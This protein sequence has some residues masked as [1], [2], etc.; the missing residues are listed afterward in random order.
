MRILLVEDEPDMA[1]FIARGLKE[2]C[3]AL[4]VVHDGAKA[5]YYAELTPYDL[6]ILDVRLPDKDGMTVCRE[7]R[8]RKIRIPI[9]MLTARDA[10]EDKVQGLDSGADDYLTKP[11]AFEELLA[12][13]RALLRRGR[14]ETDPAIA[15]GD[16]EID[17]VRHEVKRAG[18][19]IDLTGKEYALIEYLVIN[20]GHIVTR[21]M[22]ADHVWDYGFDSQTNVIDVYISYLRK[23]IDKGA[24][25]PLIHTVRGRG[26][27]LAEKP[28]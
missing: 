3:Y 27:M 25:K 14:G 17:R 2:E 12:R 1:G 4:D 10:L 26:Y 20:A 15:V 16:L 11:F 24:K 28:S 13:V 8:S 23:K 5:L 7:I 22:I 9:L 18:R 6:I 21:T 19:A